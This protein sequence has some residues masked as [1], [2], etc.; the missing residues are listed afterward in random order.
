RIA[1]IGDYHPQVKAHVAVLAALALA[2]AD[3]VCKIEPVWLPTP[4]LDHSAEQQLSGFDAIW[5]VPNSPYVSMDGALRAIRWARESGRPF[6]GTCGGFQ[7][8]IVEYARNVLGLVAADHAESNPI[9]ALPLI[10]PLA[11]SLDGAT[12]TIRLKPGSRLGAIY[13]RT[14]IVERYQC[15]FGLNPRHQSL[16]DN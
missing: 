2:A 11:C 5:C 7:H 14:E 4:S 3:L 6:L 8:A 15:N 12:G 16:L 10:S 9:A 1:L 13:G